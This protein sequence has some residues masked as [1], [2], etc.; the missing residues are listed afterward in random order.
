[1]YGDVAASDCALQKLPRLFSKFSYILDAFLSPLSSSGI[2]SRCRSSH[3]SS[4]FSTRAKAKT[5]NS[6]PA[7]HT[8]AKV[9]SQPRKR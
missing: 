4:A 5:F 8:H 9:H 3:P 7:I 2:E 1:M 6:A